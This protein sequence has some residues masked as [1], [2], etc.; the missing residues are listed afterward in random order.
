M[1][2]GYARVSTR[3]QLDGYGLD[4]Q[5]HEILSKYPTALIYE[6]Q[7]T[8]GKMARPVFSSLFSQ[9]QSGDVLVVA[10]LDRFARNTIE[11]IRVVEELF[12]RKVAIHILNVGLLE[13]TP[14]GRFFLT[15]MLAVAELERNMIIERTQ[16]G[17]ELAR[18]REGY[19]EGRPRK[20][21]DDELL[22]AVLLLDEYSYRDV[23]AL[24]GISK[25]TIMRAK[26]RLGP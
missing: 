8:G 15:T 17:K 18:L 2:Y 16:N 12:R 14:M 21:T 3:K 26:K 19:Q 22:E 9:L 20:Y 13:D 25:S 1:I 24:T 6:E 10:R 7:H 4:V 5:K 11:G 23:A